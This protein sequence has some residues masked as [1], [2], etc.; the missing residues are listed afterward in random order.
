MKLYLLRLNLVSTISGQHHRSI[1]VKPMAKCVQR[2]IRSL[3][4]KYPSGLVCITWRSSNLGP[5]FSSYGNYLSV[6][7][8]NTN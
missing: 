4:A 1:A 7:A 2:T 5:Y 6:D 3:Q 8:K